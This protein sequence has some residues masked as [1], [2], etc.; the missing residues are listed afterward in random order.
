MADGF[1]LRRVANCGDALH[2][3][4]QESSDDMIPLSMFAEFTISMIL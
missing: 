3:R 2:P 1:K 4:I